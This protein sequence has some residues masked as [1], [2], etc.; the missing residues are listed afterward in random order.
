LSGSLAG[1]VQFSGG[2]NDTGAQYWPGQFV[3][4]VLH[5]AVA[6]SGSLDSRVTVAS[7]LRGVFLG[8]AGYLGLYAQYKVTTFQ[9]ER[10][11]T[12]AF[13]LFEFLAFRIGDFHRTCT[14]HLT[15]A[16]VASRTSLRSCSDS[17]SV[18]ESITVTFGRSGQ[19]HLTVAENLVRQ[20]SFHRTTAESLSVAMQVFTGPYKVLSCTD[21]LTISESVTLSG[22][23]LFRTADYEAFLVAFETVTVTFGRARAATETLTISETATATRGRTCTDHLTVSESIT[24][25]VTHGAVDALST[26]ETVVRQIIF[27]RSV[28]DSLSATDLAGV[29]QKPPLMT[30]DYPAITELASRIVVSFH[31][32]TDALSLS[33][34]VSAQ[35]GKF[36]AA[37]ENLSVAES[38]ILLNTYNR[39]A[40]DQLVISD[41]ATRYVGL[42]RVRMA[43]D[44]LSVSESVSILVGTRLATDSLAT[45]ESAQRQILANRAVSESLAMAQ[46]LQSA[47]TGGQRAIT[48]HLTVSE[49]IAATVV[50]HPSR[51][52]SESLSVSENVVRSTLIY[53]RSAT[54]S[55]SLSDVGTSSVVVHFFSCS[56]QDSIWI[57]EYV[58]SPIR[59]IQ[60]GSA[61]DH[62]SVSEIATALAVSHIFSRS[63]TDALSVSEL[64][65]AFKTHVYT[66][67]SSESLSITMVAGSA[68]TGGRRNVTDA[69]ATAELASSIVL[70]SLNRFALDHLITSEQAVALVEPFT[71]EWDYFI[72]LNTGNQPVDAK[73]QCAVTA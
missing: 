14:D 70:R 29:R 5:G 33:E 30:F 43:V 12:D 67:T 17:L 63:A 20:G 73:H 58:T 53:V 72:P 41:I 21:H 57:S 69:L 34:S 26:S 28:T 59:P 64:A 54:D 24:A 13:L 50:R 23:N 66:R 42:P 47:V 45:G 7:N 8:N 62:L 16:D 46:A 60:T 10:T 6:P 36:R 71:G 39:T 40:T 52:A 15:L 2:Y 18:S 1:A 22:R 61:A 51:T 65:T 49:T 35:R 32:A 31:A 56:A 68:V 3:Q 38:P 44:S 4:K 48:D 27:A 55:L 37:T 19:D 11:C 9:I 25:F